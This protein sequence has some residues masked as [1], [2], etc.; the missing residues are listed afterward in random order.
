MRHQSRGLLA[1]RPASAHRRV[2]KTGDQ[3]QPLGH[4]QQHLDPI[5]R[6]AA[7]HAAAAPNHV[8]ARVAVPAARSGAPPVDHKIRSVP[9]LRVHRD[10]Q[11]EKLQGQCGYPQRQWFC[12]SSTSGGRCQWGRRRRSKEKEYRRKE[13][14]IGQRSGE[15][16]GKTQRNE[17]SM[18]GNKQNSSEK[19]EFVQMNSLL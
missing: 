15:T 16:Q 9:Q 12:N 3:Q 5:V 8:R 1:G 4:H 17:P 11:H 6:S 10:D 13:F 19:T 14:R 2:G 7:T 18:K